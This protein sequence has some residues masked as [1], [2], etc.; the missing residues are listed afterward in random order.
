MNNTSG[1]SINLLGRVWYNGVYG[2]QFD[3]LRQYVIKNLLWTLIVMD[4]LWDLRMINVDI[5][6]VIKQSYHM[7]KIWMNLTMTKNV[8]TSLE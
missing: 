4:D 1:R 2:I 5:M 6:M 8:V 3:V 7:E